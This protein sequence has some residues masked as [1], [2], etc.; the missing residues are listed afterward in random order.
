MLQQFSWMTFLIF[1]AILSALW[2]LM[3]AITVYRKETFGLIAGSRLHVSNVLATNPQREEEEE[4][5]IADQIMGKSKMPEGLEVV[6]MGALN[7]SVAEDA[8]Y[9]PDDAKSD[10]LGLVP[11]VIQEIREIFA[12]LAKED[13]TKQD[14]FSLA[15]LISEKY[16]RIGSNPNIGQ[17]NAFIRDHAPFAV[18]LEELEHLWD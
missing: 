2:Y 5:Q 7:F 14:F 1:F 18:T 6:S 9:S 11:D 12:V 3:L 16:G 8:A 4:D 10:Q 15:A 17:I 13:G